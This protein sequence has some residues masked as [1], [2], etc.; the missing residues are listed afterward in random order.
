MLN[1]QAKR[2]LG[3]VNFMRSL[4]E[5]DKDAIPDAVIKKLRRYMDDPAFTPGGMGGPCGLGHCSSGGTAPLR[6]ACAAPQAFCHGV[7][8]VCMPL[9]ARRSLL[10]QLQGIKPRLRRASTRPCPLPAARAESV[11]KQSKAAMGLCMWTRAMDVYNRWGPE[12]AAVA[13]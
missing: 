10:V 7:L 11:A 4:E 2:I 9:L 3:D 12:G 1:L 8:C 13:R 5:F 6:R